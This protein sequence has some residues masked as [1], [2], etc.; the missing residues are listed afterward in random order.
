[1]TFSTPCMQDLF[2]S[3]NL[4]VSPGFSPVQVD[5]KIANRFNGFPLQS[6]HTEETVKT[7]STSSLDHSHQ[8]EAR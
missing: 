7:V 4:L 5:A 6:S 8:A 2:S 3:I 1:M